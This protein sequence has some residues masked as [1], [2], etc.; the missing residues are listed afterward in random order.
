MQ[1]ISTMSSD[2]VFCRI[3]PSLRTGN[4]LPMFPRF[5]PDSQMN[6]MVY[7]HSIWIWM[8]LEQLVWL[9]LLIYLWSCCSRQRCHRLHFISVLLCRALS[10]QKDRIYSDS[11]KPQVVDSC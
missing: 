5:E 8:E 4:I 3:S 6:E 1:I 2:T 11:T 10:V 9:I 7:H